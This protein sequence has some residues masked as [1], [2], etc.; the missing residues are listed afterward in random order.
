[1]IRV[2]RLAIRRAPDHASRLFE[3]LLG[4]V[5]AELAERLPVVLAPEQFPGGLDP[6]G[7]T[8]GFGILQPGRIFVVDD[9]RSNGP[10]VSR[11]HAAKR[12]ITKEC[13]PRLLPAVSISPPSATATLITC[14]ADR[15][16]E[17]RRDRLS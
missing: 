4:R 16:A 13:I 2:E 14:H 12:M 17:P 6:L 1:M 5:V 10:Q 9:G 3:A 11:A 8:A 7:I 15:P